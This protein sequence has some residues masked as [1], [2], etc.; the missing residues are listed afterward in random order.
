MLEESADFRTDQIRTNAFFVRLQ[1]ELEEVKKNFTKLETEHGKLKTEHEKL[2]TEV[3]RD[4]APK[5]QFEKFKA[6]VSKE[7]RIKKGA[8]SLKSKFGS[9]GSGDGQLSS[10]FDVFCDCNGN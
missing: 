3:E 5:V 6:E 8:Y 9:R 1:R 2:K 7:Y 10:L 4:Y